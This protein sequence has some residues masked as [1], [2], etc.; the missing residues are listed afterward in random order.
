MKEHIH[1]LPCP[2]CLD[3]SETAPEIITMG[4]AVHYYKVMCGNISCNG[5]R[6]VLHK[7]QQE[8]A[9]HWNERSQ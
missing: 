1:L 8:A 7:S 2:F 5:T 3:K 9:N 4:R 6:D